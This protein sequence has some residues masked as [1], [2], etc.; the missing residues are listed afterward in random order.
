MTDL[1]NPAGKK[2]TI[3]VPNFVAQNDYSD[4]AANGELV[5]MTRGVIVNPHNLHATFY[6]Y[7]EHAQP[8]DILMFSGSNIVSAI[9]YAEWVARFPDSRYVLSFQRHKDGGRYE[10]IELK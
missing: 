10:I 6:D 1:S 3:F 5:F 8:E 7:F 9:A 2:P 4:A